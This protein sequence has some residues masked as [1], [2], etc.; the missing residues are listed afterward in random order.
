MI[1]QPKH[2]SVFCKYYI[3][4]VFLAEVKINHAHVKYL[5]YAVWLYV[6]TDGKIRTKFIQQ[7]GLLYSYATLFHLLLNPEL[8]TAERVAS[9]VSEQQLMSS[10]L[11]RAILSVAE[12]DPSSV[13]EQ[14]LMTSALRRTILYC[15]A[16]C[17]IG[18]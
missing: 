11:R 17:V 16:G 18:R 14:Q 5:N 1:V 9:S 4:A 10:S 13:A 15:R 12:R 8:N 7:P 6:W 2:K 3:D